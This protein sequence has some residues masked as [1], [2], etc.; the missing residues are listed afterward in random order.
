MNKGEIWN[1]EIPASNGHEQSGLRPA[2][3]LSEGEAGIAI[4]APFTA[5]LQAMRYNYTVSVGPS[6]SNGLTI[7]SVALVFQLRAIDSK[8]LKNRIGKLEEKPLREIE[9]LIK[10]LLKI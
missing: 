9:A 6:K 5:N 8:R 7:D 4:I 1:V 3:V 10:R 2:L